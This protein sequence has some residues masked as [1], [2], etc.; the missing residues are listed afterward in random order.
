[1]PARAERQ[2]GRI[3]AALRQPKL[4]RDENTTLARLPLQVARGL[5]ESVQLRSG[6][7]GRSSMRQTSPQVS[8][9]AYD[10]D[11]VVWQCRYS[12]SDLIL[13]SKAPENAAANQP[14]G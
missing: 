8:S 13:R 9:S 1:M 14:F 2:K 5:E 6:F 3:R 11:R 4:F 10:L 12:A 7:E